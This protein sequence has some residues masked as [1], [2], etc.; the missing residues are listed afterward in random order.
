MAEKIHRGKIKT[1]PDPKVVEYMIRPGI[2]ADIRYRFR[3]FLDC[4]RA[5]VLML[6]EQGIID[7][8]AAKKI[9]EVN[10][11]MIAMGERPSFAVNPDREDFY[12]NLEAYLIER[13]GIETGGQQHTARSRND[14]YATC[15][16]TAARNAFFEICGVYNGMRKAVIDFARKNTDAVFSGYTH[17]Q[18]SEPITLAHYCSAILNAMQRDFSRIAHCYEGLNV[19]PLGGCSMGSTTWPINRNLTS[20]LLGFDAPMENSIDCV[21]SRDFFTDILAALAIASNT[22]S[23][24]CQDLYIW[25][26][27][28]YGYLEVSDSCAVC[29]SIMPQKKNPWVLEHIRAK[30]A[31]VEGAFISS[32]NV[33]KNVIYTHSEDMSES[34]NYFFAG[35]Q[36][37][38]M[39][40]ELLEVSVQGIS[41]N[42]ERMLE[43]A[44]RNFCTV[45][46]LANALVRHD[47][48]SF[49]MAHDI[50]AEVA[51]QMLKAGKSADQIGIREINPI[52]VRLF[53]RT[54]SMND[55]EIHAALDPTAI[56]RGKNC[57]GGPAPEEVNRQ[58]A[59]CEVIL[60]E[61]MRQLNSRIK[62]VSDASEHLNR[63]TESF[64]RQN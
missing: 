12:F 27:P 44:R 6:A 17:M 51:A 52:Y 15:A 11:E 49:R 45:T 4:N 26:A 55:A 57:T 24:F 21:A 9:L 16:R 30:A 10:N 41:V 61:D 42:R 59:R 60:A 53:S 7:K 63:K 58:L 48:I 62:A 39:M 38:K 13:A 14:L 54:T 3:A 29:S 64:I 35:I 28:D 5:H 33:M 37:M 20:E 25:A 31:H 2:E 19:S 36:E 8:K 23:R 32:L 46:E 56:V 34:A 22:I 1:P 50:V 18:P 47:G 40:C 43:N